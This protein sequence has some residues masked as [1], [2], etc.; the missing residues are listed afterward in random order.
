MPR[1]DE[2]EPDW[3]YEYDDIE[4]PDTEPDWEYEEER[5]FYSGIV[6]TYCPGEDMY[7]DIDIESPEEYFVEPEEYHREY[8]EEPEEYYREYDEEPECCDEYW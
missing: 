5:V 1:Y 8:D 6:R 4:L 3:E 2:I 7:E